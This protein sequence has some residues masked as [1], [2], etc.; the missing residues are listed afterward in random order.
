MNLPTHPIPATGALARLREG[1]ARFTANLR[2][3]DAMAS[4][5]RRAALVQGQ[6]PF[7][8]VLSCS[9][10]RVPAEIV[11]DCGL[12]DLFVVR[13]AG[14]VVAP[15]LVGS[16]EFA[17]ETFGTEL[18]V[19]MGHSSCGAVAAT[20][21]ALQGCGV[22]RSLNVREIVERITP[23]IKSV[24]RSDVPRAEI[25]RAA[26]RANI[27][28]AASHLRQTSEVLAQRIREGRLL[29]VGAEYD[30][31]SGIVDIFDG[32]PAQEGFASS[33]MG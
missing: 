27:S 11:F 26:V 24:V 18:V 25:L 29:V 32:V 30:L 16:I 12:G 20:I 10:S 2:S 14:N 19:V 23:A 22:P 7:A 6:S 31:A 4:Q 8:I 13:V 28:A 9:D 5:A 1:N 17:A 21:D 33:A 3:I 15:S